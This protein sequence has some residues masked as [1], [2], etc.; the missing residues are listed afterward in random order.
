MKFL[1]PRSFPSSGAAGFSPN[2]AYCP[3]LFKDL[4]ARE[5]VYAELKEKCNVFTRR[6][7]YPLLTDFAPY[8]YAKGSC[9]VAEDAAR[10]VLTLPTYYGLS[11]A[12]AKAIAENVLEVLDSHGVRHETI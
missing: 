7:F 5:R 2:Y 1:D 6:Y 4:E 8:E 9:P 10:R 12:D 3:V 11:A